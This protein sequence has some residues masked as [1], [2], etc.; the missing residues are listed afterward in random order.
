MFPECISICIHNRSETV[1]ADYVRKL[2][3]ETG[4]ESLTFIL[5]DAR[6]QCTSKSGDLF[7]HNFK[8][9][10]VLRPQ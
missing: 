8:P 4:N 1:F 5:Y 3:E 9:T 6:N 2:G 7:V 10:W